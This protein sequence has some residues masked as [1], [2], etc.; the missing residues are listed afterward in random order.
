MRRI[1]EA[2]RDARA[3]RR[4]MLIDCYGLLHNTLRI[5]TFDKKLSN[6]DMFSREL[7]VLRSCGCASEDLNARRPV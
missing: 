2:A 7:P 4:H 3:Q 6:R 5:Y 1:D